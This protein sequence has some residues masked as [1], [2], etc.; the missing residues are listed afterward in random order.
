MKERRLKGGLTSNTAST[1][2]NN[3][4]MKIEIRQE[5]TKNLFHF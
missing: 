3:G 2:K 1:K 5:M 4:S